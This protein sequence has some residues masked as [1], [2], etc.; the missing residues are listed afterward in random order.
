MIDLYNPEML[1]KLEKATKILKMCNVVHSKLVALNL[2]DS[3]TLK[4]IGMSGYFIVTEFEV[5]EWQVVKNSMC[6]FN[7]LLIA[8]TTNHVYPIP[9]E[10]L[11]SNPQVQPLSNSA[12]R[13]ND[14]SIGWY[15]LINHADKQYVVCC[16]V[17]KK[18]DNI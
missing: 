14:E 18:K 11:K 13:F 12:F 10:M 3:F 15:S 4:K 9:Y 8:Q 2:P 17:Y 5:S 16:K 7:P 6:L 1:E